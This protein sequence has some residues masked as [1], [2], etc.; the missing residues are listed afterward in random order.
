MMMNI[1]KLGKLALMSALCLV[2][3]G[4]LEDEE[5]EDGSPVATWDV[6]APGGP[7]PSFSVT[8]FDSGNAKASDGN[9]GFYSYLSGGRL[10]IYLNDENNL[11]LSTQYTANNSGSVISGD[12]TRY[13]DRLSTTPPIAATGTFT[14]TLR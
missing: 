9:Y 7:F 11:S 10:D 6:S 2:M 3:A 5:E 8:L 14:A 1:F 4:C 12:W 13:D